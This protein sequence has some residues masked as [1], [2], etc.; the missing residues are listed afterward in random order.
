MSLTKV[1]Y[2]MISG[3]P[4]NVLD[5]GAV[6][7]GVT[8]DTAAIQAALNAAENVVLPVGKYRITAA[9]NV[10][11]NTSFVGASGVSNNRFTRSGAVLEAKD[12]IIYVDFGETITDSNIATYYA[13]AAVTLNAGANFVGISFWYPDQRYDL[14]NIATDPVPY[15][16]ALA[17]GVNAQNVNIENVHFGNAYVGLDATRRNANVSIQNIRG[18][19]CYKGMILGS[20]V[21]PFKVINV[22]FTLLEGWDLNDPYSDPEM[23]LWLFDNAVGIEVRRTTW[24]HYDNIF[25]YGYNKGILLTETISD[26][27]N[28]VTPSGSAQNLSIINSGFDNNKYGIYAQQGS[29]EDVGFITINNCRFAQGIRV[30]TAG[31]LV[32]EYAIYIINSSFPKCDITIS[33]CKFSTAS[34][35]FIFLEGSQRSNI[36]NNIFYS[37]GA[38]YNGTTFPGPYRFVHLKGCNQSVISNNT[39]TKMGGTA[40]GIELENSNYCVVNGNT[41][42]DL[43][44]YPIYLVTSNFCNIQDNI[45]KDL[46]AAQFIYFSSIFTDSGVANNNRIGEP[47]FGASDVDG[48]GLLSIPVGENY[49]GV[50]AL[51]TVNGITQGFRG[52]HLYIRVGAT[53]NTFVD[54]NLSTAQQNRLF[55]AGNF[56]ANFGDVLHLVSA[57]QLG[58]YEVSRSAN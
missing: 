7:D 10:P 27:P 11:K 22:M 2:S 40:K 24:T 23:A 35:N 36:C 15:P 52:T 12:S 45:G 47:S 58:W 20:S 31:D 56:A 3:A 42:V 51:P 44:E 18:M 9:L 30:T 53:G 38:A 54:E 8:D 46:G 55:L 43:D 1:T 13:N 17:T 48:A 14:V 16:P 29:V 19:P 26:V 34:K 6:G 37:A 57:G 33:S 25:V 5:Y 41:F 21:D 50:N 32:P 49:I 39:I 28:N 4:V